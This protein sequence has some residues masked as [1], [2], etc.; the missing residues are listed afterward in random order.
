MGRTT[1]I[2]GESSLGPP[3]ASP[4]WD[5]N[6]WCSSPDPGDFE[7]VQAGNAEIAK[8]AFESQPSVWCIN[9]WKIKSILVDFPGFRR[10]RVAA[11]FS[12]A[13]EPEIL[14]SLP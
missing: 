12:G 6:Y 5:R 3:I 11:S 10:P 13:K 8:P 1:G 7:W 14:F 4:L 9:S 2:W